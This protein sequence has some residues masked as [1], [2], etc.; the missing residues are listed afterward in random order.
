MSKVTRGDKEERPTW[1]YPGDEKRTGVNSTTRV[2][3]LDLL[4]MLESIRNVL[5]QIRDR[6][7]RSIES[8]TE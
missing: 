7:P 2:S 1:L 5:E 3:Q 4:E 6:L 8:G